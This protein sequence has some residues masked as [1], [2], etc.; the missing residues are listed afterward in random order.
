MLEPP[1][2][3]EMFAAE[4]PAGGCHAAGGCR[5]VVAVMRLLNHD[6]LR[7]RVL[8]DYSIVISLPEN[9]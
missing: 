4:H 7:Q 9:V 2:A 1:D 5:A 6:S 8:K 3:Y